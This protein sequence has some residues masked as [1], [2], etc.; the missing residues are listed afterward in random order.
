MDML[1]IHEKT[2][3]S[4]QKVFFLPYTEKDQLDGIGYP[5]TE[6][7]KKRA[8]CIKSSDSL[9]QFVFGRYL[10]RC[11]L[12]KKYHL[13]MAGKDF[14]YNEFGKPFIG[15]NIFFNL[16]HTSGLA[17]LGV[18]KGKEN[19]IDV[20]INKDNNRAW[21][22]YESYIKSIG[23]GLAGIEFEDFCNRDTGSFSIKT[24]IE[25]FNGREYIW[26]YCAK[27]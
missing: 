15:G 8:S 13:S 18:S 6:K 11:V 12:S 9:K 25:L 23:S 2:V 7:E 16:S 27:L 20:E 26:S 19:G 21:T 10:V 17:V 4:C 3:N 5:L 1:K 14:F 22:R 24:E